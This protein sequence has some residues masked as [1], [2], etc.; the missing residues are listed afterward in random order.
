MEYRIDVMRAAEEEKAVFCMGGV[1][2]GG[3]S[4][5]VGRRY[6][7][8]NKR[9]WVPVMGEMHFS[10][11]PRESWEEDLLKMKAAGITVVSSYLFW[12]HHEEREGEFCWTGSRDIRAFVN[13]CRKHGLYFFARLGPWVHG[14]CRNGGHPD[15]VSE[16]CP[17][18]RCDDE[19]YLSFVRRYYGE[20]GRQL[21]GLFYKDGGPVIGIQVENELIRDPGHLAT[22][23]RMA[24]ECGM[25]APVYTVTGWGHHGGTRFPAGEF[26]PMFGG[27]PE[28]P[29]EQH[30]RQLTSSGHYLFQEERN[31][32]DIGTDVLDDE[33]DALWEGA[34]DLEACPYATCETGGG[35]PIS[36]HRRPVIASG[37]VSAMALTGLGSGI[38]F[39]GY[40][41]FKGGCNPRK[42]L[43]AYN[44]TKDTGYLNN[45]PKLCNDFQAPVSEFGEVRGH[46]GMLKRL[47]LFL[48]DYG[49][50]FA[51]SRPYFPDRRPADAEDMETLRVCARYGEQGGFLFINNYIRLKE[52]P[53]KKDFSLKI[54]ERPAGGEKI[55]LEIPEGSFRVPENSFF[56]LP[57]CLTVGNV[58]IDFAS[59]QPLCRIEEEAGTAAVFFA[60]DEVMAEYVL[61]GKDIA[62]TRAVHAEVKRMGEK[63]H[64]V[65]PNPG[66]R[67]WVELQ[68]RD[69]KK[70]RLLTLTQEQADCCYKFNL[71][72]RDRVLISQGEVMVREDHFCVSGPETEKH[73][74]ILEDALQGRFREDIREGRVVKCMVS[75]KETC[76]NGE[77]SG[78][79]DYLRTDRPDLSGI[80]QWD[81]EVSVPELWAKRLEEGEDVFLT[82]QYVGDVAH[83]YLGGRLIADDF[84]KGTPWRVGLKRFWEELK[85]KPLSLQILP[86]DPAA[87]IYFEDVDR[88]KERT[89]KIITISAEFKSAVIVGVPDR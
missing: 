59:V 56:F 87:P 22:L 7:L 89:A 77:L 51:L 3:E 64:I 70:T 55:L 74:W 66:I 79:F 13:L 75:Y 49:E 83:L 60:V 43:T 48:R 71:G 76:L 23:K 52:M 8:K 36:Y 58:R 14:E 54:L 69:G 26:V 21:K 34:A 53:A 9:P 72:G 2:P 84:Y 68:G 78:E 46:Y 42:G 85:E 80:R 15:W 5:E 35:I 12:I 31:D 47:N 27:Y 65:V 33:D 28:A 73:L 61:D 86:L 25:E 88:V 19:P 44:E 40:F 57:F 32:A 41:M 82:I 39:P 30:T 45:F 62:D 17:R 50:A 29:W 67:S 63:I 81:V 6:I 24:K 16:R 4:I 38:N 18:V 37:D 1:N 20:I 11:N 10:R